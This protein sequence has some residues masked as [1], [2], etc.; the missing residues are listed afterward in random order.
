[1]QARQSRAQL[2]VTGARPRAIGPR[3]GPT[4]C[5]SDAPRGA[6]VATPH[7]WLP[8][9]YVALCAYYRI[10]SWWRPGNAGRRSA[11]LLTP[12]GSHGVLPHP[13]GSH[14]VGVPSSI[15]GSI[16]HPGLH[17][18]IRLPTRDP[19]AGTKERAS[20]KFSTYY[21]HEYSRIY[22]HL[23]NSDLRAAVKMVLFY[24]EEY[25]R[26]KCVKKA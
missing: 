2:V 1:M 10:N 18:L 14:G 6:D 24:P 12:C 4:P 20:G 17:P 22:N 13:S 21:F 15:A 19:P 23:R 11:R 7:A 3:R 26:E 5:R 8:V 25:K 16:S 9:A